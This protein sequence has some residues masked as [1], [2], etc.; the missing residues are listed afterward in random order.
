MQYLYMDTN[1]TYSFEN[2]SA[3]S[4]FVALIQNGVYNTVE[5]AR[6]DNPVKLLSS[7]K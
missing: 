7:G 2:S 4:Q 3:L 1:I 5:E 6:R